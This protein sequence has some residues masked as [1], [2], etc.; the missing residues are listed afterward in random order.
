VLEKSKPPRYRWVIEALLFLALFAQAVTWLAPA[1]ILDPIIRSLNLTL[2]KAGLV[3]SIFAI[4]T[5]AFSF[6]SA[7]LVRRLGVMP[8]LLLGIWLMALGQIASGCAGTLAALLLAR[9]L[10]GI[11][12]GL[13]IAPPGALVM[14]WFDET[15][16]PWINTVNAL[17]SYIG[18]TAVYAATV[19]ILDSLGSSWRAV[20]FAYGLGVAGVAM[21]WSVLG[22]ERP[23]PSVSGSSSLAAPKDLSVIDVLRMRDVMLIAL[24]TFGG[25]W[26]YQLYTGFLPEFFR[27]YRGLGL[28]DASE[29]T[30]DL[31]LAAIFACAGAGFGTS[32]LGLRKPF[33]W[34]AA[35]LMLM[36]AF[37]AVTMPTVGAIRL[38]L[39]LFG[40]GAA[41][42]PPAI[43]TLLMELPGMTPVGM[44]IGLAIVWTAGYA[45]AFVSPFLGGAMAGA[46]GLRAVMLG[47]LAFQLISI[48]AQYLLPE[49]GPGRAT[50][51][52]AAATGA[53]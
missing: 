43:T 34:P 1:P 20:L 52:I 53:D 37:G 18:A 39:I 11:G 46:F 40:T 19:P 21:L 44:G 17:S 22:R 28:K 36:G 15:A 13:M 50:V 27:T 12:F 3:I 16:W 30:A 47:F 23:L 38:S 8:T 41:A 35:I 24:G 26:V 10:Q 45:G 42:S 48:V 6:L 51:E 9:V 32:L 2:G 25:M 31:P 49:T 29:L 4:C 14:Q 33:T 7:P 5:S